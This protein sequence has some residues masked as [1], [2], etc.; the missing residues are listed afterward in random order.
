MPLYGHDLDTTT[1]PAQGALSWS[2]PKVRRLGG[3]R[4]GGFPGADVVL[5][6]LAEGPAAV[7]RGLRPEGRAPIREG[8]VLF[9]DETSAEP[10]GRVTSGTFGPSIG[11][12]V[13]MAPLP[14][15][16]AGTVYAELRGR[17]VPVAIVDLPFITP[18]YKR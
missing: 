17:R 12:P 16:I 13:A 5:A 2:I 8:V 10:I 4:E 3:A 7:R 11:A 9:A 15:G 1:T 6:E 14:A 18:S